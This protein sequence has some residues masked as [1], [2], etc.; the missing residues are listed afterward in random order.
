M[1]ITREINGTPYT[2]E[3]TDVE[4]R[5]AYFEQEDNYD[6]EDV[7]RYIEEYVE[8]NDGITAEQIEPLIPRIV[9]AYRR[10]RNNSDDWQNN[11][12]YAFSDTIRIYKATGRI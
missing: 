2:F 5:Q 3:L 12:E 8:D 1:K 7:K 9:R 10:A 4:M 11:L 6:L